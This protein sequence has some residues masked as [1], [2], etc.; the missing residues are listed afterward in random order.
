[1]ASAHG[2]GQLD[3]AGGCK[4]VASD[5][6]DACETSEPSSYPSPGPSM[7]T[8]T[9]VKACGPETKKKLHGNMQQTGSVLGV[10]AGCWSF[11]QRWLALASGGVQILA[12]HCWLCLPLPPPE[13][14]THLLSLHHQDKTTMTASQA[15]VLEL[16]WMAHP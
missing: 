11:C 9:T 2:L 13:A 12:L 14:Q 16:H 15:G 10:Q 6:A 1:M 3:K 8:C 5:S 4:T 7:R